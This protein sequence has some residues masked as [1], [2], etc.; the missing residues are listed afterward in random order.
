[1]ALSYFPAYFSRIKF[2][3]M[4][5]A[6]PWEEIE[7]S[8]S[9]SMGLTTSGL[10]RLSLALSKKSDFTKQLLKHAKGMKPVRGQNIAGY[11]S[12][13][14]LKT[15]IDKGYARIF[16]QLAAGGESPLYKK[17]DPKYREADAAL[18]N[19][20]YPAQLSRLKLAQKRNILRIIQ[21]LI[22]R[23][24]VKRYLNDAYQAG[25]YWFW[26]F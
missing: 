13:A 9:S 2:Y 3:E 7:R 10:E 6:G 12:G 15:L 16:R 23:V 25:N 22:G 18:L 1:M 11:L 20:I 14:S 19:L 4:E 5:D 21:P 26:I 8:N 17:E 24:G